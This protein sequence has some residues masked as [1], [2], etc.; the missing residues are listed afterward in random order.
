L[1]GKSAPLDVL[2]FDWKKKEKRKFGECVGGKNSP[3][4]VLYYILS[5]LNKELVRIG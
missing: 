1:G 2:G 3:L 4:G 5:K